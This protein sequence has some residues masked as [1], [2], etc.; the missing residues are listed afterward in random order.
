M[1]RLEKQFDI[2]IP[3][4]DVEQVPAAGNPGTT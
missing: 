4:Q 2:P 1:S 3:L